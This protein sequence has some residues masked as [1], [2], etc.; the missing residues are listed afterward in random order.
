M[1]GMVQG[2]VALVTGAGSGIGRK[3]AELLA[4]EG[5]RV[6]VCDFDEESGQQTLRRIRDAG[7][8]ASF[9]QV[10]VADESQVEAMVAHC[11]EHFG[12]LD[13]AVNN[14]GIGGPSGGLETIELPDWNRVLAVNLTG[15]FLCMKHEIPRM[16]QQQAGSIVNMSSGAGLI[17]TPGLAP[18]SASK[19]GVLGITR[20][21][22]VENARLGVRINAI[23]PGSIDTPMLRAAMETDP[24]V[25]KMIRASMPIGRLG[26]AEEVAEAV[27]WLCSDRSS[28]VT[29]HSMGVDGASVA[30]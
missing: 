5:A 2:K 7:G 16:R 9:R 12:R 8:E 29:G 21:A 25:E 6:L 20:S 28:L 30:R 23:C 10:D 3:S 14:A 27:V 13:S 26:E 22:A 15:V 11:V 18:Y 1:A 17:A 24:S 19:H 4:R